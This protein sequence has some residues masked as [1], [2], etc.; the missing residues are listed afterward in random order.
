MRSFLTQS[1]FKKIIIALMFLL[2]ISITWNG[3]T[4]LFYQ[5]WF[6][7]KLLVAPLTPEKKGTIDGIVSQK[8]TYVTQG[9]T[10]EVFLSE[11]GKYI[12]KLFLDKPRKKALPIFSKLGEI[13]KSHKRKKRNFE[14]CMNAYYLLKEETGMI[15]YH[16]APTD[17]FTSPLILIN[18][19]GE[20]REINLDITEFFLQ[21]KAVVTFDY[22]DTCLAL[23]QIEKASSAIKKLLDFT[24]ALYRQG[25]VM[26][27]LQLISNFGFI[28]DLPT[29]ID[30][31]HIEFKKSW[32]TDH[33]E[34]LKSQIQ[35]FREW[36]LQN[37][38][39]L[40]E[41]FDALTEDL[42]QNSD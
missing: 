16:F 38:T 21:K 17:C 39:P 31:E 24:V 1:H 7:H 35:Y 11:D 3:I 26:V 20:K 10:H 4:I 9:S 2:L 8:F 30:I 33:K 5:H 37:H 42:L 41:S 14:G 19:F 18:K 6:S 32:K 13:R 22:L 36:I 15:Y 27:D 40:L 25:I 29:R 28:D 34:H 12:L 23:N